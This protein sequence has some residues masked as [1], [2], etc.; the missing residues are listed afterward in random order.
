MTQKI[1]RRDFLKVSGASAA[2]LALASC[3]A[4]PTELP[5]PT[6]MNKVRRIVTGFNDDGKS[7]ILMDVD[8]TNLV[9]LMP[10]FRAKDIWATETACR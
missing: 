1:S 9:E 2:G 8:M 10:G 6:K 7:I 5:T 4:K 3:S